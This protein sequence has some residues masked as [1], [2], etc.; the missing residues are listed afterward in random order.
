MPQPIVVSRRF[1]NETGSTRRFGQEGLAVVA[2]ALSSFVRQAEREKC[3]PSGKGNWDQPSHTTRSGLPLSAV[4]RFRR[5]PRIALS[6]A[7]LP[8]TASDCNGWP[9][10]WVLG[11]RRDWGTQECWKN[12]EGRMQNA[13]MGRFGKK[14]KVESRKQK[15]RIAGVIRTTSSPFPLDPSG[16]EVHRLLITD[17]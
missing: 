6:G 1:V 5:T 13:E 12:E 17:Y 4:C 11:Q 10:R 2:P 15:P 3:W 7:F 16:L 8:L 9:H 14:Y